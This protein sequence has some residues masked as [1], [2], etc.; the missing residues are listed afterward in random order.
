[1]D[2]PLDDALVVRHRE[3]PVAPVPEAS[4]SAGAQA[5]P[6]D[7]GVGP[8]FSIRTQLEMGS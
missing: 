8:I 6:Q 1:M 2:Q 5:S 4:P 7:L 3:K